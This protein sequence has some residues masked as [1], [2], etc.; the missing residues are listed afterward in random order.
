MGFYEQTGILILGT[1]FRR[2]SEKFLSEISKIYKIL[3]IDFEPTWFPIFYLL[4]K[5]N[6][7][8]VTEISEEL[9]VSQP[10]VSQLVSILIQKGFLRLI[11]DKI[12]KRKKMVYFT[13][14][15]KDLLMKLIPIWETME[16]SMFEIFNDDADIHIVESFN[17][18]ERKINRSCLCDSV[19][20]KL[21]MEEAC[22]Y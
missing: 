3:N 2:L 13:S 1:R 22:V 5:R 8:S 9:T 20:N 17:E 4:Y 14:K 19:I 12:D 6:T 11:N 16:K 10:A 7:I 15:G 18:L 21:S